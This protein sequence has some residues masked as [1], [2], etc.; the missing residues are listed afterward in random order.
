MPTTHTF[1]APALI[2]VQGFVVQL[3][4]FP[5]KAQDVVQLTELPGGACLRGHLACPVLTVTQ[6]IPGGSLNVCVAT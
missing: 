3:T 6:P 5:A 4:F 2:S 1:Q